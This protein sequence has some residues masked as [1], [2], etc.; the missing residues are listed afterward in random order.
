MLFDG[1]SAMN[2]LEQTKES[3]NSYYKTYRAEWCRKSGLP[4]YSNK[5]FPIVES[6]KLYTKTRAKKEKIKIDETNVYAWYRMPNGYTPLFKAINERE[7]E[8]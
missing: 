1:E 5:D 6:E 8:E 4:M 3:Y 2:Y 7:A